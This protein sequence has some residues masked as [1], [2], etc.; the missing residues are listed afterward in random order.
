M[1]SSIM[2]HIRT[3]CIHLYGIVSMF[4]SLSALSLNVQLLIVWS[5][6]A[7]FLM[8]STPLLGATIITMLPGSRMQEVVRMLPI[9]LHTVQNLRQTFNELSLVIPVAPHR[10]VRTYI[11]KVVQSGPFPVVLIPGG[12]LKERYDAFSVSSRLKSNSQAPFHSDEFHILF[13]LDFSFDVNIFRITIP[14]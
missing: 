14:S 4:L 1:H 12:S 3:L 9:F 11:E 8:K 6:H 5:I 7:R 13:I 2:V 10:Y